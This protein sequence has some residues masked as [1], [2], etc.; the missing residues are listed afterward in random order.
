M[1]YKDFKT[2]QELYNGIYE[3]QQVNEENVEELLSEELEIEALEASGLFTEQELGAIMEADSLAA[4][5]ARREKRLA[6]Q[7]KRCLLYTSDAADE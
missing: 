5:Q 1:N 3:P 4:M 6:A 2:I 7:R